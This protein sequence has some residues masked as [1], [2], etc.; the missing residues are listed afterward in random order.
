MF[1]CHT[2]IYGS[3]YPFK[4]STVD[5]VEDPPVFSFPTTLPTNVTVSGELVQ[6][7]LFW[8]TILFAS[9]GIFVYT[10]LKRKT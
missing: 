4:M 3:C 9:L 8:L 7:E 1:F 10:S 2:H 6:E 5:I